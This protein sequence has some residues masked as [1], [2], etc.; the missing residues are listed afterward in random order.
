MPDIIDIENFIKNFLLDKK[1]VN[2]FYQ[3]RKMTNGRIKTLEDAKLY[4]Q[5]FFTESDIF[6]TSEE[7]KRFYDCDNFKREIIAGL[8]YEAYDSYY[9]ERNIDST[10]ILFT[11]VQKKRWDILFRNYAY[12]KALNILFILDIYIEFRKKIY[13]IIDSIKKEELGQ[14]NQE[15]EQVNQELEQVKEKQ[16]KYEDVCSICLDEILIE[17]GSTTDCCKNTF[18]TSCIQ[19]L[20]EN[21]LKNLTQTH[22]DKVRCPLCRTEIPI[23]REQ[24]LF[25][26]KKN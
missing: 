12:N 22:L 2:N 9:R 5:P 7:C 16:I 23:I 6:V 13:D 20:C 24:N 10:R 25:I 1:Y 21:K 26:I 4:I 17:D 19:N 18:H 3:T 8:S 14:V 11:L 15:L